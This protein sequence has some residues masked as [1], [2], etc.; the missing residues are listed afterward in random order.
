MQCIGSQGFSINA[1]ELERRL[2]R[3]KDQRLA[4]GHWNALSLAGSDCMRR[5]NS[6][7]TEWLRSLTEIFSV[8]LRQI[9]FHWPPR[10][11]LGISIHFEIRP[12]Q[13]ISRQH[14]LL[15]IWTARER[16]KT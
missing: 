12:E 15:A 9:Q 16:T 3:L 5:G 8:E 6:K 14:V 1:N 11:T 13:S 10:A 7:K 4:E 2:R